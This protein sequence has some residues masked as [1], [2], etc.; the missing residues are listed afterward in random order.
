[1]DAAADGKCDGALAV[2][3]DSKEGQ[4]V[5]TFISMGTGA[6]STRSEK[7][8]TIVEQAERILTF[9]PAHPTAEQANLWTPIERCVEQTIRGYR[10]L[11]ELQSQVTRALTLLGEAARE[12]A[13]QCNNEGVPLATA[14]APFEQRLREYSE[15]ARNFDTQS[16]CYVN[17]MART[18]NQL[19]SVMPG[20][21]TVR[22]AVEEFKKEPQLSQAVDAATKHLAEEKSK[23]QSKEK[24]A[25]YDYE[26]KRKNANHLAAEQ[27]TKNSLYNTAVWQLKQAEQASLDADRRANT[28]IEIRSTIVHDGGRLTITSVKPDTAAMAQARRDADTARAYLAS[29]RSNEQAAAQA[30]CL[31]TIRGCNC[32]TN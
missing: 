10:T 28:P 30:Q 29:Q 31:P 13:R 3:A 11:I 1:M 24:T 20:L 18:I 8:R 7:M 2:L 6:I 4:E 16:T 14:M 23:L 27:S 19:V 15:I 32:C 17:E 12:A 21:E 9:R 26:T 25:A 22:I 5:C